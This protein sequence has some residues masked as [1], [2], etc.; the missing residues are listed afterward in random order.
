MF[1]A[2]DLTKEADNNNNDDDGD[3][4]KTTTKMRRRSLPCELAQHLSSH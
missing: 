2:Y 3:R 1:S 4:K